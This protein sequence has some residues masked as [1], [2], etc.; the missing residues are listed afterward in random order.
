MQ[1]QN[2]YYLFFFPFIQRIYLLVISKHILIFFFFSR[3]LFQALNAF[4]FSAPFSVLCW[5]RER[6][7]KKNE[8]HN[9]AIS[10]RYQHL[11]S[12]RWWNK[13]NTT[14]NFA[15]KWAN[16]ETLREQ[17]KNNWR[18]WNNLKKKKRNSNVTEVRRTEPNMNTKLL[19]CCPQFAI[20]ILSKKKGENLTKVFH[21]YGYVFSLSLFHLSSVYFLFC[22]LSKHSL[23][24][25]WYNI[26]CLKTIQN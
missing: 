18:K 11:F 15:L 24:F 16:R 23:V 7:K 14:L 10:Q 4:S 25:E 26:F 1:F 12:R 2:V 20:T 19:V 8:K 13:N 22:T 17:K 9:I 5:E 3:L 6:E 21:F